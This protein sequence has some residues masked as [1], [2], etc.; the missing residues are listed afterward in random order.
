MQHND[1]I[2]EQFTDRVTSEE[3]LGSC[4]N[5]IESLQNLSYLTSLDADYPA[6]V[7]KNDGVA[8]SQ[9]VRG[10]ISVERLPK[11]LANATK[12]YPQAGSASSTDSAM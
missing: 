5:H 2:E 8:P 4:R 10:I 9:P 7:R 11:R 12:P 1:S 3:V 6:R